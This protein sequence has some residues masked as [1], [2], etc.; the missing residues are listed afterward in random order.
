MEPLNANEIAALGRILPSLFVF[1]VT[2][3]VGG[4]CDR[5]GRKLFDRLVIAFDKTVLSVSLL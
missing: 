3:S 4:T 2:W 1:A 5:N